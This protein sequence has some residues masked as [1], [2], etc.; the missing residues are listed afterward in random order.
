MYLNHVKNNWGQYSS[1]MK[2]KKGKVIQ[3]PISCEWWRPS[4]GL[5]CHRC[6]AVYFTARSRTQM[7]QSVS[8]L[9]RRQGHV[10]QPGRKRIEPVSH[11]VRQHHQ[12]HQERGEGVGQIGADGSNF[13]KMF[14]LVHLIYGSGVLKA[15]VRHNIRT[16][17]G[18]VPLSLRE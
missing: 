18:S 9:S 14:D 16:I 1:L 12:P 3:F 5:Q 2:K 17:E 11:R 10:L 15:K 13:R 8:L 7:S 6:G 4:D